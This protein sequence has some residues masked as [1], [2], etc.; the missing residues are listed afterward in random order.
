MD[1]HKPKSWHGAREFLKGGQVTTTS[2]LPAAAAVLALIVAPA[3][4]QVPL[5]P[6]GPSL[7]AWNPK[8][9]QDRYPRMETVY[10][11]NV[12]HRGKM[13]RTL[14]KAGR[15]IAPTWDQDG[16]H[17]TLDSYMAANRVSGLLVLQH[18]KVVT[19]RYGL[20]RTPSQRWTSFSVA[21]SVTSTL[22]G[23]AVADGAIKSLDDPV[24]AYIR[25]LK[26]SAYDQVTV[27]QLLTMSSG[28]RWNEDYSDP[29]SDVARAGQEPA[30]PGVNPLVSYMRKLPRAHP[31]GE[32]F[33][34][35]TG[36]T[37]LVGI[38][39]S[40][41]TG[42]RLADYAS[43]KLWKP[44]GM[45]QD[46]IWVTDAAGHER[47]GCCISMTLRD[48]GRLGEFMLEG[49]VA[50]GRRIVPKDWVATATTPQI[51]KGA[52]APGY[53]YFW[54]ML[55]PG[56]AAE[57]I[58]GQAVV[59]Y[60]KDDVVIVFNSAWKA[61]DNDADWAAQAAAAEAIRVALLK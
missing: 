19:E 47:G 12:I 51:T 5:K 55:P 13:V 16:K 46:A 11:A 38:L 18:G 42:K 2:S 52:P 39:V 45:E 3:Q 31:P 58:F 1:I 54:W 44:I 22:V 37:D 6:G 40:S 9:Q 21:K 48:Y 50:N 27:R 10:R 53:G 14:P 32:E 61:A 60:P 24:T 36:E 33:H 59:V 20:G 57:G 28:V 56:Y 43:E 30:D 17:W 23:A 7:L 8:Q 26:G 41:A 34:Y 4:A 25:D 35:D 15:T 29:K 49:G